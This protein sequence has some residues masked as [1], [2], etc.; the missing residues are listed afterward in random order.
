MIEKNLTEFET[1]DE[2]V[3]FIGSDK[4]IKPNVSYCDDRDEVHYAVEATGITISETAA[5]IAIGEEYQLSAMV[6]PPQATQSVTWESSD[7]SIATVDE[8]GLVS[9]ISDGD[10][11]ITVTSVEGGFTAQCEIEIMA[12]RPTGITISETDITVPYK[13]T[14]QLSATVLPEEASQKVRWSSSDESIATVDEN[15]VV[16][17]VS[18]DGS[19]V[20][21]VE[22]VVG[23][24]QAHCNV[25]TEYIP[26]TGL[27]IES[28]YSSRTVVY[29][30]EVVLTAVVQPEN[31]SVTDVT[32][33]FRKDFAAETNVD[34]NKVNVKVWEDSSTFNNKS[35]YVTA[36]SVDNTSITAYTSL[37]FSSYS[38][39]GITLSETEKD[40]EFSNTHELTATT[41]PSNATYEEDTIKWESSDEGIIKIISYNGIRKP[42]V[43]A[44]GLGDATVTM[45]AGFRNISASCV[46]HAYGVHVTGV[47]ISETA[48][49]VADNHTYQLSATVTPDDASVKKIIWSS[50]DESIATVDQ[51]GLVK[52]YKVGNCNIIATAAD[53]GASASCALE[54]A[55]DYTGIYLT[56]VSESEGAKFNADDRQVYYSMDGGVT[57]VNL[58]ENEFTPE[59]SVGQEIL[60]KRNSHN[61]G[62]RFARS[63][64]L[65]SLKGNLLSLEYGDDFKFKDECDSDT[66]ENT[67]ADCTGLTSIE[68]LRIPVKTVGNGSFWGAFSGCTNLTTAYEYLLADVVDLSRDAFRGF[69]KGCTSLTTNI[70]LYGEPGPAAIYGDYYIF[71]E[72][73]SG[74]SSIT[75]AKV[76]CSIMNYSTDSMFESAFEGCTSLQRVELPNITVIDGEDAFY[77][78]F[79]GCT[80]LSYIELPAERCDE[81]DLHYCFFEWVKG[82]AASGTFVKHANATFWQSGI[83]GIPDGWT[84][85]DK[86]T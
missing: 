72:M 49:T 20:I 40:I 76:N 58:P 54:V 36:T 2:Y 71:K 80:N 23:G 56:T 7:N 29:G 84:V 35:L 62:V 39:T 53:G 27:T 52:A 16:S 19:C 12:V 13:R 66:F 74:C 65:F 59:T 21:T 68:D 10:V 1:H 57:W 25:T 11:T 82:V 43:E 33:K 42:T 67:F 30:R 28:S 61:L 79:R 4:F 9:A 5:V 48:A 81:S 6:L 31:A 8:N 44:V 78:A 75:F 18:E 63:T 34:G 32:F 69:Y 47:S 77:A 83:D 55:F 26:V 3:D 70:R 41:T 17:G 45:T 73:C 64:G 15:G 24:Y 85:V 86:T 22:S 37:Q 46:Y 50:S 51:N 14:Y 60:W 38:I